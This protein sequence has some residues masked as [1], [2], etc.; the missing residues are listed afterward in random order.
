MCSAYPCHSDKDE[1]VAKLWL[2]GRSYSAA[3]ERGAKCIDQYKARGKDFYYEKAAPEILKIGSKLDE[4]INVL[5]YEQSPIKDNLD[6]IL[7]THKILVDAFERITSSGKPGI[8]DGLKKRSLA[9][10]YL[11][12]HCPNMFFI[13]DSIANSEVSKIIKIPEAYTLNKQI[14]DKDYKRFVRKM[15]KLQDTVYQDT[16]QYY[17]PRDLDRFLLGY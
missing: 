10:K 6:S 16:L 2:I 14:Y 15:I 7:E 4:R 12:F 8:L 9:S 11:H 13:Y 5:R 17:S 1:I 3:L